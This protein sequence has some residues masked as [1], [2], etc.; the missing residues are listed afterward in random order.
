MVT[1]NVTVQD[2]LING[3]IGE[4]TEFEIMNSIVKNVYV[5]FQNLLV[6]RNK[7]LS[8]HFAQQNCFVPLQK[9]D[10]DIQICKG[11]ISPSIKQTQFPL[12]LSWAC[13]IHK[14]QGLSLE[15][16]V[17]NFG[18]HKQRTFGQGQM[19]TALK[20]VSSHDKPFCLGK[21]EPSSIKVNMN[22]NK[23]MSDFVKIVFLKILRK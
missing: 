9:C 20:R 5:K 14:V 23:N 8:D 22:M 11:S 21:S 18:L 15:Q 10:A 17:V 6:G 4:V 13:N 1:V 7:I 2:I 19:Y 16:D 12:T 3:Q